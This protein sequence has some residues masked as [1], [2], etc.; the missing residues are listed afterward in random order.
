MKAMSKEE[1]TK[2]VGSLE[3]HKPKWMVKQPLIYY[4][5]WL[6]YYEAKGIK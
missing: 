4:S 2:I 6:S 1:L 5:A 3:N